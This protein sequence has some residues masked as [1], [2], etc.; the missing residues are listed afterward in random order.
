ML[1]SWRYLTNPN[2]LKTL[3][4]NK[5]LTSFSKRICTIYLNNTL[6]VCRFES[7]VHN[8]S[9]ITPHLT[10]ILNVKSTHLWTHYCC[11]YYF[12]TCWDGLCTALRTCRRG[13]PCFRSIDT[14]KTPETKKFNKLFSDLEWFK[15]CIFFIYLRKSKN[16][17][18]TFVN[19][20]STT[21]NP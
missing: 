9:K 12:W 13:K 10:L 1:K 20:I 2:T 17:F 5:D 16:N 7:T 19:T 8:F 4:E 21:L 14:G 11:C 15:E 18:E 3:N 6:I